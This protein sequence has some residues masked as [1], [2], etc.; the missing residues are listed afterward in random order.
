MTKGKL[1]S[2]M[3][4]AALPLV[5]ALLGPAQNAD[6]VPLWG[7]RQCDVLPD[8]CDSL[9]EKL[10]PVQ[11]EEN[12]PTQETAHITLERD[13]Y[14]RGLPDL[15][16][17]GGWHY[18]LDGKVKVTYTVD[19]ATMTALN[20]KLAKD[21][22]Q[23][24]AESIATWLKK[25]G[26]KLDRADGPAYIETFADGTHIEKWYTDGLFIRNGSIPGLSAIPGIA[27]TPSPK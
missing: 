21:R 20:D 5:F 4:I 16:V 18:S 2:L 22:V 25:N 23:P 26:A 27:V 12:K 24:D 19:A 7:L 13:N 6:A 1:S 3:T 11:T 9:K 8:Q 17:D 14:E 15:G 10:R